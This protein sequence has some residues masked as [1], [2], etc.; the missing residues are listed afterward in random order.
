MLP[1]CSLHQVSPHVWWFTPETRRDRPSLGV[2]VGARE[3]LLL[4]VGA[5]PRHLGELM[6]ALDG[7]GVRRPARAVLTHWHWDHVFGIGAFAGPVIAHRETAARLARMRTWDFS[8]AGLPALL[9]DGREI[10]FT[11]EHMRLELSDAERCAL[12]LRVPDVIIDVGLQIDIG[13][14]ACELRH[15]GGDHAPDAVVVHV[16]EDRLLFLGDCLCD[17]CY[18]TPPRLTREKLLPLIAQLEGFAAEIHL[19]G[20]G[21]APIARAELQRWIALI[22]DAYATLDRVGLAAAERV[23][24]E[25]LERHTAETVED[26]LPAILAGYQAA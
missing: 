26:F 2:V 21:P 23:R 11:C 20:H 13:G 22:R 16:P 12:V 1:P 24:N 25:L 9:A 5:S 19:H 3:T 6:A 10:P 18:F 8:D 15:V 17:D 7:A 4:D 14:V